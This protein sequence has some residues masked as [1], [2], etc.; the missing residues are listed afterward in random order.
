M[1]TLIVEYQSAEK[2]TEGRRLLEERL[3]ELEAETPRYIFETRDSYQKVIKNQSRTEIRAELFHGHIF[4]FPIPGVIET[5]EYRGLRMSYPGLSINNK[6]SEETWDGLGTLCLADSFGTFHADLIYGLFIDGVNYR[7]KLYDRETR[8]VPDEEFDEKV[9]RLFDR[10][11][12][13][14]QKT[15]Q[16]SRFLKPVYD[17]AMA[18][19]V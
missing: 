12:T 3:A 5:I 10:L 17:M 4:I 19:G 8:Q 15:K 9:K 6:S 14:E 13:F 18:Y 11:R 16:K 2:G 1:V 7:F